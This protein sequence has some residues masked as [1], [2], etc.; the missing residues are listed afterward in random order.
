MLLRSLLLGTTRN[1]SGPVG[2]AIPVA[3]LITLLLIISRSFLVSLLT[4]NL[5][6]ILPHVLSPSNLCVFLRMMA[7][8]RVFCH[9]LADSECPYNRSS[10]FAMTVVETRSG[11][12]VGRVSNATEKHNL[13]ELERAE[14]T[15]L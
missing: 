15:G 6:I 12:D 13:S 10:F 11:S 7:Q 2:G 4:R 9:P 1:T 5:P 3:S 8:F 14:L